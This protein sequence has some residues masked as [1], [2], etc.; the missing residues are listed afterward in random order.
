[1]V[2]LYYSTQRWAVRFRCP[3]QPLC[4][5]LCCQKPFSLPLPTGSFAAAT[6]AS[7]PNPQCSMQNQGAK[8]TVQL[9]SFK[10]K[11][12][13][14][15]TLVAAL[16]ISSS[17]PDSTL[18]P[19]PQYS[20]SLFPLRQLCFSDVQR[21][22]SPTVLYSFHDVMFSLFFKEPE[23]ILKLGKAIGEG[24]FGVVHKGWHQ[25]KNR[26]VAIKII[27]DLENE[28]IIRNELEILEKVSGHENIITFHGAFYQKP[29]VRNSQ[30]EG[31]WVR[32]CLFR[33]WLNHAPN[34][35]SM[36]IA[37]R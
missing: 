24:G 13:A 27:K 29:N 22:I 36:Y 21:V 20:I 32:K 5:W 37:R 18:Q 30:N 17:C 3:R 9:F 19:S 1:M 8:G 26:Q 2:L 7:H 6:C 15:C 12:S 16:P 35:P 23:R 34:M 14:S 10:Q 4:C 28:E 25:I 31:L 33:Y 11:P